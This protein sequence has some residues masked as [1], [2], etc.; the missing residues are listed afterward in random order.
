MRK[1]N[2]KIRIVLMG[3]IAA[4]LWYSPVHADLVSIN[5]ELIIRYSGSNVSIDRNLDLQRRQ[6]SEI[7][8][9]NDLSRAV[10]DLVAKVKNLLKGL[11]NR[12]SDQVRGAGLTRIANDNARNAALRNKMT[13]QI[14]RRQQKDRI[15]A[16]NAK[17][18]EL[19]QRIRDLS[20]R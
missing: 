20:R 7:V 3:F 15:R 1:E 19:N 17:N 13:Q 5:Q 16:L 14:Q 9:G 12:R 8:R 10:R 4:A 6:N 11:N 2:R 18:R